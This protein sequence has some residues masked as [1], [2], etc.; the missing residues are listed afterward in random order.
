MVTKDKPGPGSGKAE[1]YV[2]PSLLLALTG[3]KSYGYEL[4]QRI[5]EYGF[6][7]EDPPPGMI[8]RHLRQM[9]KDS[10]V[11]SEWETSGAGPAKRIYSITDDGHEMLEFWIRY[12]DR[13]A[14]ALA[15]FVARYE[16]EG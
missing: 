9:E 3:G 5:T 8:Y 2:Q 12:M 6:L 15:S 16:T 4:I 14:K 1:R 10:L 13:Q 7:P 11:V